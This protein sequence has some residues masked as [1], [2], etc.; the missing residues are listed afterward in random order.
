MASATGPYDNYSSPLKHRPRHD[1]QR[2][3]WGPREC[4]AFLDRHVPASRGPRTTRRGCHDELPDHKKYDDYRE[5]R[6]DGTPTGASGS[7]TNENANLA[8]NDGKKNYFINDEG[9]V[10]QSATSVSS[11]VEGDALVKTDL[12]HYTVEE[13]VEGLSTPS[14][15][16][17]GCSASQAGS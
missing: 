2:S 16:P 7:K 15:R 8:G 12:H 13:V 6:P 3:R 14:S 9:H 11:S 17:R 1:P 10:V 5:M 4:V